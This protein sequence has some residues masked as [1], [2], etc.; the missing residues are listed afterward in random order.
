[1]NKNLTVLPGLLTF[2]FQNPQLNSRIVAG[3]A[4]AAFTVKWNIHFIRA[5]S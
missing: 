3:R 4:S 2:A 1:M 5:N